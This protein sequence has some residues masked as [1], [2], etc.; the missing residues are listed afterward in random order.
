MQPNT[1]VTCLS[2]YRDSATAWL[3]ARQG[4]RRVE[5]LDRDQ[6]A[7]APF[8]RDNCQPARVD[9]TI[10]PV[11]WADGRDLSPLAGQPVRFR[12]HL[13]NGRLYALRA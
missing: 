8:T 7:I 6:R 4:E 12:F 3:D 10:A 2:G 13:S 1:N 9:S 11:G 5:V